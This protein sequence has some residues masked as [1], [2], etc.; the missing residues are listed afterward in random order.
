M[1]AESHPSAADPETPEAPPQMAD[2][3]HPGLVWAFRF[4]ADGAPE[5][6]PVDRPLTEHDGWLWLHFDVPAGRPLPLQPLSSSSRLSAAAM[7]TL[8]ASEGHPQLHVDETCIYGVF[9][10]LIGSS[11]DRAKE[12]GFIHFAMTDRL[13]VSN[14]GDRSDAL[15]V[16][17]CTLHR[18]RKLA[19]AASLLVAIMEHAVDA[20]DDYAEELG[21]SLDEIE[22]RLLSDEVGDDRVELAEIRRATL[23]LHRQLTMSRA[24]VNRMQADVSERELPIQLP[25][26][27]LSQRLDWLDTEVVALRD[28]AHLLQDEISFKLSEQTNQH[29]EVLSIVATIFLPA[30]LVAGIFGMNFKNLPLTSNDHG[31]L[32]AMGILV[33]ASFLVFQLLKRAG[34]LGR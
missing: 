16:I 27:K 20:A 1:T 23:R 30:S 11:D 24:L 6:L 5:E 28:R 7:E 34:A 19:T 8:V 26:G 15:G 9:A 29:L 17:R 33:G 31:F 10:N 32:W 13:L 25:I 2:L 22:E 18:G 21:G 3:P 4:H 12:I 14:R